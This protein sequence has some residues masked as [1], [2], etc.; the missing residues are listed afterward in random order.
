M[1]V[2]PVIALTAAVLSAGLLVAPPA[3][4]AER[5][6]L[7]TGHVDLIGVAYE[8]GVLDVHVHD[9]TVEPPVERE[10]SEVLVHALPESRTSVPDDPAF[11]FLGKPGAPIWVL[12]QAY[13]PALLF[14]GIGTEELETG[15]FQSDSVSLKLKSV[16]GPGR[17]SVFIEQDG[18]AQVL[19][20]SGDGLPDKATV[21]VA[22]H[23][24][25]NWAF[26][27]TGYYK[28]TVQ[29][30]AKLAGNGSSVYSEPVTY[31]FKVG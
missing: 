27:A 18:A 14:A 7:S 22:T 3:A 4:A 10:P 26:S 21:P 16:R 5:V 30:S 8:D 28:V 2:R 24:H 17:F 31:L 20:N 9:D 29:A 15:V 13:N 12:P 11:A 23:K 1:P 25:V 6:V 19:F